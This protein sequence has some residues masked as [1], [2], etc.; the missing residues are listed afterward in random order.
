MKIKLC[1]M[2][3]ECDIEYANEAMPDYIG[4][5]FANTRRKISFETAADFRKK[6]NPDIKA[7][8]VFVNE[9][10][11][12]IA[13]L[14]KEG[15]I[16]IAQLH[17]EET[18][19]EIEAI[20]ALTDKPLIKAVKVRKAEDIR[21]ADELAVEFLLFDTF[22]A[23]VL[24]GTGEK[25]DWALITKPSKPFFL[26]GGITLNNIAEAMKMDAYALDISSGIETEGFKDREKMLAAV[27]AIRK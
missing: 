17:G 3:L 16:D 24:G 10:P 18:K 20:R 5:I 11:E 14:L 6:L 9:K 13:G 27:K 21:K 26:A 12:I 8:G 7:V 19:E 15:I 22:K 23:G 25:F 2:M 4:F 1:G